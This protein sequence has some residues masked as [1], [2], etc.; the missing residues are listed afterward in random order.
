M[1]WTNLHWLTIPATSIVV[2]PSFPSAPFGIL[3][4]QKTFLFFG[5][6]VAGEEIESRTSFSFHDA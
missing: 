3:I 6:L 4:C 5:F 2:G 1:V